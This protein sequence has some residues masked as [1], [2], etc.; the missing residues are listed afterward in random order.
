MEGDRERDLEWCL[1]PLYDPEWYEGE[2]KLD[3]GDIDGDIL[4]ILESL[5]TDDDAPMFSAAT[6]L[7]L[8]VSYMVRSAST[9]L[10]LQFLEWNSVI[11]DKRTSAMA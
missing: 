11:L 10:G 6:R 5:G 9:S 2:L 1:L 7:A 4:L 3:R 8:A